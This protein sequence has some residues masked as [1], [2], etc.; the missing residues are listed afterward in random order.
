MAYEDHL[1]HV[2][3]PASPSGRREAISTTVPDYEALWLSVQLREYAHYGDHDTHQNIA[4][5]YAEYI[6][7]KVRDEDCDYVTLYV[8]TCSAVDTLVESLIYPDH[9]DKTEIVLRDSVSE[10]FLDLQDAHYED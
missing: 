2:A 3:E 1:E 9:D 7:Q 4:M 10:K 8:H 5:A 6:D